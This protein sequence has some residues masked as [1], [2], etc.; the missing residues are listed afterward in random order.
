MKNFIFFVQWLVLN[1]I[2]CMGDKRDLIL[3][4]LSL[5]TIILVI[6]YPN[7]ESKEL[8]YDLE[9]IFEKIKKA[10]F[11]NSQNLPKLSN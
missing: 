10:G 2:S 6:F 5:K 4:G 9:S 7:K 11:S 3:K 1:N 8:F